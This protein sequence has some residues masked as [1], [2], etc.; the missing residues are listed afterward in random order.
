MPGAQ[1]S[2]MGSAGI[3]SSS[4]KTSTPIGAALGSHQRQGTVSTNDSEW[5]DIDSPT[6]SSQLPVSIWD[7]GTASVSGISDLSNAPKSSPTLTT[8]PNIDT[9]MHLGLKEETY[10]GGLFPSTPRVIQ[11]IKSPTSLATQPYATTQ[12]EG[13][14]DD[15]GELGELA[16]TMDKLRLFDASIYYGKGTMLFTS[17]DQNKFWDEE[18]T[19]DVHDTPDIV[20][21][22][23][24]FAMPPIEVIDEL[25]D[26]YY[27]VGSAG[28][29]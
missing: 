15:E 13:D 24:A 5:A 12:E 29:S 25:F 17:T 11:P 16:V 26:I 22:P 23:E 19:F 2:D 3:G 1:L 14:S 9:P 18:I 10:E 7:R 8:T 28:H 21:P 4:T 6:E 27:R 20:I